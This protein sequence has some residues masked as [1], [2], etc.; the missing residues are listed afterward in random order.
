MTTP[1]ELVDPALITDVVRLAVYL[2][3]CERYDHVYDYKNAV[4]LGDTP[5]PNHEGNWPNFEVK[6]IFPDR[7]PYIECK[8]CSM[9]WI[10]VDEPGLGYDDAL[11]KVRKRMGSPADRKALEPKPKQDRISENR[12]ILRKEQ[13]R[14]GKLVPREV[15]VLRDGGMFVETKQEIPSHLQPT[16]IQK[17]RE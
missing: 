8:R 4:S 17:V 2:E 16:T 9:V 14:V 1:P 6:S 7:M 10:V 13:R 5:N 3:D 15:V 11:R 12:E